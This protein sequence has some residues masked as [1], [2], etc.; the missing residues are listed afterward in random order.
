MYSRRNCYSRRNSTGPTGRQYIKPV[1]QFVY[2]RPT[3]AP[4]Y[5]LVTAIRL[6]DSTLR[7]YSTIVRKNQTRVKMVGSNT[8]ASI[9]TV[10]KVKSTGPGTFCTKSLTKFIKIEG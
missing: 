7:V 3:A 2:S 10:K 8:S 6:E 5:F 4:P 9:N 1:D